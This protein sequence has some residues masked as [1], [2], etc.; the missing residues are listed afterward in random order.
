MKKIFKDCVDSG[1]EYCPCKLAEAGKCIICSQLSG[2]GFCDCTSWKGVCIYNEFLMSGKVARPQR[3]TIK[4]KVLKKSVIDKNLIMLIVKIP[5]LLGNRLQEPGSYV[6]IRKAESN[7]YF[8]MPI[9]VME[10]NGEELTLVIEI[11]GIKTYDTSEIKENDTV[12]IR[13]PYWNGILGRENLIKVKASQALLIGRGIGQAPLIPVIKTLNK[14]ENN[15]HCI[16][17]KTPYQE[18]FIRD[19]AKKYN[20][21]IIEKAFLDDKGE[22]LEDFKTSFKEIMLE[23]KIAALHVSGP[24]ILIY[25]L[26]KLAEEY[27]DISFSCCNNGHFCC[28]EGICGAC[29]TKNKDYKIERPCKLQQDPL[30]ILEG[31]KSL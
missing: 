21:E 27:K 23:N 17:D 19:N 4:S 12:L 13:G 15:I 7:I 8:D 18:L 26:R 1:S 11:K 24:D 29:G 31:R 30:E 9:S 16:L 25:K 3:R 28:G 14:N 6:F 2:K 22:L 5:E 20:A 10:I